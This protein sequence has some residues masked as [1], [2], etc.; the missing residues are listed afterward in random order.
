KLR[1]RRLERLLGDL[2]VALGDGAGFEEIAAL[3]E[4]PLC[5]GQIRLRRRHVG[6]GA[7]LA[8]FLFARLEAR[9]ELALRDTLAFADRHVHQIAFDPRANGNRLDGREVAGDRDAGFDDVVFDHADVTRGERDGRGGTSTASGAARTT[10]AATSTAATAA[11][12]ARYV[13]S[14]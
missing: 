11:A 12:V 6:L 8:R 2:Q 10:L 14:G 9:E 4:V 3:V 7:C 1:L 13:R 5:R